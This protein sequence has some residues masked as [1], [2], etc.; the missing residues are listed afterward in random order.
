MRDQTGFSSMQTT[1]V[2]KPPTATP[3]G[4]AFAKSTIATCSLQATAEAQGGGLS[5]SRTGPR[6]DH[7]RDVRL[8]G[9][10]EY[11]SLAPPKRS[12]HL[13]EYI[14]VGERHQMLVESFQAVLPSLG[15]GVRRC[16]SGLN[17]LTRTLHENESLSVMLIQPTR[18]LLAAIRE[19]TQLRGERRVVVV[20]PHDVSRFYFRDAI[21]AKVAA[22]LSSGTTVERL[23]HAV[24]E[25]ESGRTVIDPDFIEDLAYAR[26]GQIELRERNDLLSL[27]GRQL[28]VVRL[29]AIGCSTKDVSERL[30]LAPKTVES[31]RYRAMRKLR[32]HDRVE[33]TRRALS[34][35]LLR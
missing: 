34:E 6:L 7:S 14:V 12:V 29:T 10:V 22:M 18:G 35:G 33:L 23:V 8:A 27:T 30:G 11:V 28:E 13:G 19:Q 21:R 16:R 5:E 15:I 4:E 31:H 25:V 24:S 1:G 26:T 17:D 9:G 2:L 20:C 3:S 32:V